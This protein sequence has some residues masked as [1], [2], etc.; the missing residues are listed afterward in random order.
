M[1]HI[2]LKALLSVPLFWSL[3]G[4]KTETDDLSLALG[5]PVHKMEEILTPDSMVSFISTL[6]TTFRGTLNHSLIPI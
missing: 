1:S 2:W 6:L 3:G 4:S 5:F